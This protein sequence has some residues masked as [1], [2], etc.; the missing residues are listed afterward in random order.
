MAWFIV[1][2]AILDFQILL[3]VIELELELFEL[4]K[5]GHEASLLHVVVKLA[6]LVL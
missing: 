1:E 6:H 3:V 2:Q 4:F 5:F